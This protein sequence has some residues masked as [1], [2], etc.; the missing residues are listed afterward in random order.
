MGPTLFRTR[1]QAH[2]VCQPHIP[3]FTDLLVLEM[4]IPSNPI[5]YPYLFHYH[6]FCEQECV[7]V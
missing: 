5:C 7:L 3:R 1:I 6:E 2:N 4:L